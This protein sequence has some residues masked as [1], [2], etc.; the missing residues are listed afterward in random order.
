MTHLN[1]QPG[2]IFHSDNLP[3]FRDMSTVVRGRGLTPS[4]LP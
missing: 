3:V 2:T 4:R 1:V